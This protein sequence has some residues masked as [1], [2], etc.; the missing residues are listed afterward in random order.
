MREDADNHQELIRR[1]AFHE[2]K[3]R[4]VEAVWLVEFVRVLTKEK[5]TF[6]YELADD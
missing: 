2:R 1:V 4:C 6:I 5:N 3:E